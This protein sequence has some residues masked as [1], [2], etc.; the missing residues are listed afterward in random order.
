MAQHEPIQR[1]LLSTE[2][3]R[4][5]LNCASKFLSVSISIAARPTAYLNSKQDSSD[6]EA[7]NILSNAD[8]LNPLGIWVFMW[9]RLIALYFY[10]T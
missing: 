5:C 6:I 9:G 3:G 4:L 8:L 2:R 10:R 7:L 1:N